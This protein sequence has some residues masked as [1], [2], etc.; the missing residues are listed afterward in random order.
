MDPWPSN[1]HLFHYYLQNKISDIL[2]LLSIL[3]NIEYIVS[4]Q[5]L[6]PDHK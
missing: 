6:I 5:G 3:N 4:G 2:P 1:D